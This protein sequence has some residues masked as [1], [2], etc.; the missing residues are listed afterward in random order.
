MAYLY[1]YYHI[2]ATKGGSKQVGNVVNDAKA[3]SSSADRASL[4]DGK[5]VWKGRLAI[6]NGTGGGGW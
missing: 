6:A 4:T 3:R 5:R 2:K 1:L